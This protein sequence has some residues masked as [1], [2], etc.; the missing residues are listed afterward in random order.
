MM[1]ERF[2][3]TD[4][5][6]LKNR[7]PRT[8]EKWFHSNADMLYTFI[9]YRVGKDGDLAAELVQET[10]LTALG[11][12]HRY[13][14]QRGSMLTW[15]SYLSRNHISKALRERGKEKSY[16]RLWDSIDNQ[17]QRAF[18]RIATQPLPDELL[19]RTETTE[20]VQVTLANIPGN[21]RAVLKAYYYRKKPIRQIAD[22]LGTTEGAVKALL[23]R[24]RNA[25]GEAF[26]KL[27]KSLSGPGVLKGGSDG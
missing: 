11:Q 5:N 26:V 19:S 4:W 6:K 18:G 22:C 12:I 9:Y 21:Y 27:D 1:A 16:S 24:A 17:L 2:D 10:F 15:L 23:H 8:I 20:L 25:F 13:D 3:R 7:D 14:P